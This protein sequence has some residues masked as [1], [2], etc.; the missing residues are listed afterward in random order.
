MK[1]SLIIT[2][3]NWPS[4]LKVHLQS[5]LGQS[6]TDLE[7]I[8]ADDGSGPDTSESIR[9]ILGPSN[10]RWCHVWHRD[11][12]IRQARVKNLGVKYSSAPYLIFVDH[13]VLLHPDFVA[14]H[15]ASSRRGVC[16]Q[17][18]RAFL[19]ETYTRNVLK[20]GLF[21][22]PSPLL[23][24]L[25]NRKNSFRSPRMGRMFS[26]PKRFQTSLRGC[27]LS[28]SR[29][30]FLQVDG[31]DETFD[32]LWGREDSDICYRLFHNGVKCRNLWFSALQYHL[33]HDVRK[34]RQK[35]RLDLELDLNRREKRKK[36]IK[37]FSRLSS[38]GEIISASDG[39][40][41]RCE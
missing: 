15:L 40:N 29:Q 1:V 36:A 33:H 37:G 23:M 4:A 19:P 7:I 24:G 12:G 9:E 11:S 31:Y 20:S 3:Y 6:E 41:G 18:K 17:G 34:N 35:D 13:D 30:D 39:F 22:R 2:T 26:R 28:M 38:E 8:I 14:D 27:N 21:Y 5:I 25:E 16:L 10:L 32:Q